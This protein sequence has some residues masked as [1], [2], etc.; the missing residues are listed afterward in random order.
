M[1]LR[2]V[3]V[4]ALTIG[5]VAGILSDC[6]SS[7]PQ[8]LDYKSRAVMRTEGELRVSTAVLSADESVAVYGVPLAQLAIQPVWIEV[9][10]QDKQAYYLLSP[11][12]DPN[13]IPAS[14]AAEALARNS[15][16][17]QQAAL[18]RR[19]RRLALRNPILP[20][21]TT[22]GFVLANLDSGVKLVQL[23]LVARRE[24]A[25]V[26]DPHGRTWLPG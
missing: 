13:F 18:E 17:Q 9:E 1:K 24:R 5:L 12:L 15:S 25:D 8:S 3:A 14:E 23:D 7:P 10:N 20:G 19:F 16:S 22:S 6:A 11:G 4:R 21:V 26:L 2:C